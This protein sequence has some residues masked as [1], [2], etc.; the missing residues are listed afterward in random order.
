[1]SRGIIL[2]QSKYGATK[3]YADWLVEETGYDCIE[4]KDAKVANLQNYDVIILG[5]GV[6]ASGIAGLQ[7]IKKN[8]GRL[9][10]KKIV[11]FAIGASPYD[12]KAIMQIRKMHFKD[13]LRNIPLFYCRGAWDEEKMKFT[14]RTLCKMLQK[15]VAKQNPDEY[16]P[17][18]KALMCAAGQKCDW[19]DKA[20]LEA[21]LKYIEEL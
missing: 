17:W 15:V 21:L 3:K 16:E 8:I 10:N 5:G 20:Y 2:Y 14:D 9:G 18:Q 1:M 4:T 11:V 12:E 6:Y 19:T 7:F 13:E